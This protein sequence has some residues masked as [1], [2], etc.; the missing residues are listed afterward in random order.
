MTY[1]LAKFYVLILCLIYIYM[2]LFDKNLVKSYT[3]IVCSNTGIGII[4]LLISINSKG[5]RGG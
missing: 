1:S 4:K 3:P 5:S 2:E